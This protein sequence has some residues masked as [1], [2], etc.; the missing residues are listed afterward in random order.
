MLLAVHK[1]APRPAALSEALETSRFLDRLSSAAAMPAEAREAVATARARIDGYLA[2]ATRLDAEELEVFKAAAAM[3]P[4][5]VSHTFDESVEQKWL[6]TLANAPP[7]RP[8]VLVPGVGGS[9]L[10]AYPPS[11]SSPSVPGVPRDV[12]LSLTEFNSH[13]TKY[14]GGDYDWDACEYVSHGEVDGEF[15]IRPEEGDAG[16]AA[17]EHLCRV[18]PLGGLVPYYASFI[19]RLE[20]VGYTRGKT[21]F[22]APYDWR[23]APWAP[24]TQAAF[25]RSL[26]MAVEAADGAKV[27]LITHSYGGLVAQYF[28]AFSPHRAAELV[29]SWTAIGVPFNGAPVK[30]LQAALCGYN[31]QIPLLD[32]KVVRNMAIKAPILYETLA[33]PGAT[34]GDDQAPWLAY[35]LEGQR[36]V[37]LTNDADI[38][39]LLERATSELGATAFRRNLYDRAMDSRR[40]MRKAQAAAADIHG[41]RQLVLYGDGIPT[42]AG[43]VFRD[44]VPSEAALVDAEP[45]SATSR[46]GEMLVTVSSAV[47][48]GYPDHLVAGAHAFG[49]NHVE[50]LFAPAVFAAFMGFRSV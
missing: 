37:R 35:Q 18:G 3:L 6:G 21:L 34:W 41:V 31:F 19:A 10:M 30:A 22:G 28:L 36:P 7:P 45:R 8:V 46:S 39:A 16:L 44:A 2:R 11:S 4:R 25:E 24:S 15:A 17:I 13:F 5:F 38:V 9:R 1:A 29:E 47:G 43:L 14:L 48:S 26:E 12:Y 33:V 49:Y 42:P 32:P 20:R 27:D 40:A 50:L 23:Q